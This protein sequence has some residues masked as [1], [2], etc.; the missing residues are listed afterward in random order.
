MLVEG[1]PFA[2]LCEFVI[3]QLDLLLLG[4][5]V[6]ANHVRVFEVKNAPLDAVFQ[7]LHSGPGVLIFNEVP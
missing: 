4:L 5:Q 6:K 1:I 3:S 7:R 2:E